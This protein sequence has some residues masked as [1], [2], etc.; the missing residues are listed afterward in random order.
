[1][2][3]H[4]V[5]T[6]PGD[7]PPE[8]PAERVL[9]GG[10]GAVALARM[11]AGLLCAVALATIARGA[12]AHGD[13]L[14]A[15][16][17]RIG[18]GLLGLAAL[19]TPFGLTSV[20]P[21]EARVVLAFGRYVGTLRSPGLRW[22][23]PLS[24]RLKVSTRLRTHDTGVAKVHDGDGNPIEI[25]AAVVWQVSDTAQ[26]AFRVDDVAQFV[27]VQAEMAL[28]HLA[29]THPY[30]PRAGGAWSLRTQVD[31]MADALRAEIA[32]GVRAAGVRVTDARITRL[33]YA[34]EIAHAM[35]Q[36]QQAEAVVA[37]RQRIVEGAVGMVEL[38][39]HRLAEGQ[40]VTLDEERK[41]AMVSN[42]LVVLCSDR[43]AHPVINAGSL[44]Q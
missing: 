32:E 18:V 3:V 4:A 37:A 8:L 34:P 21:G 13:S 22:V 26:A 9:A 29:A 25:A 10:S 20:A 24:R 36:R 1:M 5:E 44:Y 17:M 2:A 23:H 6:R 43:G 12:A 30:E 33:A 39:L 19:S 41:A 14:A 11:A 16:A 7:S 28:R 31:A 42:L 38:A 15:G 27:A 35:L 40:V